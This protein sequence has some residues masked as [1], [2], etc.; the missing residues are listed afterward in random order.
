MKIRLWLQLYLISLLAQ[1]LHADEIIIRVVDFPPQYIKTED[2]WSGY[3]VEMA[4][5][6]VEEAGFT[7]RFVEYPWT[8]ALV[9]LE[10]GSL[11]MMVNLSITASRLGFIQY[12]GPQRNSEL[13]LIVSEDYKDSRF[14]SLDALQQACLERNRRF[15]YQDNVHYGDEFHARMQDE[16]FA[17]C[18]EP[19]SNAEQNLR[20]TK[21]GRIM[22]FFEEKVTM[23]YRISKEDSYK[24]LY[25]HPF[26]VNQEPVFFGLSRELDPEVIE[27]LMQA[28][29]TLLNSGRLNALR[30]RSW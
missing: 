12:V 15:G 18:F 28:Y 19:A 30:N 1:T 29:E 7:P 6:L 2:G 9:E 11:H 24:G 3:D 17:K 22:G 4:R 23:N 20:K 26:T 16:A 21:F 8:R 5:A 10:K 14:D 27:R 25:V 13:V